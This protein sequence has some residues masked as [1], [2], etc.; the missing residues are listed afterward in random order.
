[1]NL[2]RL[3]NNTLWARLFR[4][5]GASVILKALQYSRRWKEVNV[6]GLAIDFS[7]ELDVTDKRVL[8]SID[9]KKEIFDYYMLIIN[10]R[11]LRQKIEKFLT[12]ERF[13]RHP[14]IKVLPYSFWTSFNQYWTR[15]DLK[16][17]NARDFFYEVDLE[18]DP[19]SV[20]EHSDQ[21]GNLPH[22]QGGRLVVYKKSNSYV[23]RKI[24]SRTE[25]RD[26]FLDQQQLD[27]SQLTNKFQ[28][29]V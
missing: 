16:N 20:E 2:L 21:A 27:L 7:K 26:E 12:F 8:A 5:I 9:F 23:K 6:D 22:E 1:M 19:V 24:I 17:K 28:E 14:T 18:F 10:T 29:A 4:S 3:Q 11:V 15:A 25:V 13:G